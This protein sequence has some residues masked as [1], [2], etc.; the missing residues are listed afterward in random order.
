MGRV[1]K[2]QEVHFM[3][4]NAHWNVPRAYSGANKEKYL[5]AFI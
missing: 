4:T 1:R 2:S 3:K 5:I